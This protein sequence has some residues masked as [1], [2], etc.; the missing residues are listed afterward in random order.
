[1]TRMNTLLLGNMISLIGC[2]LMV[3][4][5][6]LKKKEQILVVQCFQF[7][8]LATAN[9][10]LGAVSGAIAGFVGIVRNLVFFR[11]RGTVWLKVLFVGIQLILSWGSL[12]TGW[13]E[14]LPMISTVILTCFLDVKSEVKLKVV[15]I[16]TQ[17]FWLVYDICYRNFTASTF[18][19]LTVMSNC[20]GIWMLLRAQKKA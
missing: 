5:G 13:L 11:F 19:M 20:I 6:F 15:L 9:L 14:W 16:I 3:G 1:M 8:I 18:D 12:Q 10:I 4:I 17:L 2:V 7:G